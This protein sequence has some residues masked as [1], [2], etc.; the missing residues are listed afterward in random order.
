MSLICKIFSGS[1]S[2]GNA[3]L[4]TSSCVRANLPGSTPAAHHSK[5]LPDNCMMKFKNAATGQEMATPSSAIA[6]ATKA[7]GVSNTTVCDFQGPNDISAFGNH[8]KKS[9]SVKVNRASVAAI[10]RADIGVG[11]TPTAYQSQP[12]SAAMA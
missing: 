11:A 5:R 7:R 3:V 12:A 9:R 10:H 2:G 1:L 4:L 8:H 6:A